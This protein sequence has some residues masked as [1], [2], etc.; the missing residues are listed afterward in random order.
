MYSSKVM[1]G[2]YH[3]MINQIPLIDCGGNDPLSNCNLTQYWLECKKKKSL[4]IPIAAL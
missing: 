2:M 3:F 4:T 1:F